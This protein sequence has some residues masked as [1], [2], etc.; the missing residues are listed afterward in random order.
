LGIDQWL[1]R[2]V[3][4]NV[5]RTTPERDLPSFVKVKQAALQLQRNDAVRDEDV[6][7]QLKLL[8]QENIAARE[9]SET[10]VSLAEGEQ[11]ARLF[12]EEQ[13]RDR[14]EENSRLRWRVRQMEDA[15]AQQSGRPIDASVRI[16]TSLDSL[17]PW[18]E[19]HLAGRLV[20]SSKAAKAAKALY[21]ATFPSL[22][23]LFC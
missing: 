18:A 7:V 2:L 3:L 1:G 17:K 21:F 20:V 19:T 12:A 8:R 16:P 10:A 11:R 5:S 6:E 22:I 15:L 23:R 9:D 4:D 14:E 13:V